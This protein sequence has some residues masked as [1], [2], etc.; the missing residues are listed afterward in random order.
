MKR[1]SVSGLIFGFGLIVISALTAL[2]SC[3][4]GL[5]SAVDVLTPELGI[6]YPAT[7]TI[8]RG[9]FALSGTCSDDGKI[10]HITVTIRSTDDSVKAI[11]R[12][13]PVEYIDEVLYLHFGED[14][15]RHAPLSDHGDGAHLEPDRHRHQL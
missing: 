1:K 12:E 13:Y 2:T 5:G 3:E 8:V 10:D 6:T 7:G 11:T 15:A 4:V 14:A 9:K